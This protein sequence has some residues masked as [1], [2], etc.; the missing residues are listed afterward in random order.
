MKWKA[1]IISHTHWDRE[2]YLNSKY[3]NEWLVPFFD[4]LLAM[5]EKEEDYQFV[6][7]GQM[8]MIDDY[9]EE[10]AKA[11]KPV[12][13]FRNKIKKYVQE[14]R[15][16][17]GP[18]YLQPDWQL[19]S[20]ESLVRNMIVG[21]TKASEYGKC[22]N[23]GWLLDNFGQI[24]QTSQ[25][26]KE[27]E[28]KGLY[29]WRGVEMDPYNLQSEFIW[30][31]PDGTKLPS[32]YL[33]NSYRNVMR[34]A[35]YSDI[36]QA[37]IYA[38]VDKLKD[39]MTTK[40][41]LMM[42][43]YDQEM[44]PDDIQPYIKNG[45]LDSEDI[46]VV[47]SNP[48]SYLESVL[49]E[50]PDLVTLKG[51]LY[52]GRF[53][54]V[55]PGVMSTR[56][57]LKLQND[58]SQKA[59]EKYAEPLALIDYLHGGDYDA[60]TFEKAWELL[61]KNHPHDSICGVSIDDVHSD[62]EARSRDFH[63]LIDH[64][65]RKSMMNLAKRMDTSNLGELNYFAFN[66]S[67]YKRTEVVTIEGKDTI[68]ELPAFGYQLIDESV[69]VV[70]KIS[71]TD[72]IIDNGLI[73]V[74]INENGTFDIKDYETDAHY[75]QLGQLEDLGDAG[76]EYNYSYPDTDKSYYSTDVKSI[77]R[78]LSTS[79][80][81]VQVEV[82]YDIELPEKVVDDYTKRS[83]K[84]MKM[85]VRSVYTIEAN[86]KVVKVKTEILNTVRDHLVRVLFP[87]HIEADYAYAGS[88][89]DV[90]KRPIHIDDYD[91]S[92]IPE[93]VRKV[94]VGAREAKPN[95]IFFGR[96][97]VDIND[98][99]KGLAV[100][101]KGLPEYTVYEQDNTIALTLFRSVDWVAKDINTRIGDAGPEI[102]TPE[103][104]CLRQMTFEYA[105]YPHAHQYDEGLVLREAD[106]FNAP[107][108]NFVTDRHT[109]DLPC[110]KEFLSVEDDQNVIRVTSIKR[111]D[112]KKG[113]T[114][115]MYNGGLSQTTM[116]LN[117][118]YPIKSAK[119]VNFL[120][121]E[122]ELLDIVQNQVVL[123][124]GSKVIETIYIELEVSKT[125]LNQDVYADI[126]DVT[127]TTDFGDYASMPLVTEEDIQREE[128]RAKSWLPKIELPLYRRTALEAQLSTVLTKDRYH[129]SKVY[130]LGYELN[131]ARVKRRVH[132]YIQDIL[133]KK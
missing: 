50:N 24:S 61:L 31:S 103:A 13:I 63:F 64:Q 88:P 49:A 114:I 130:E 20:E 100:L 68:I 74:I 92:M 109:G 19:L 27:A 56:M 128:E 8:S 16:F 52:S 9:Y 58:T 48:E 123:N 17:V 81:K 51:A 115:R 113:I 73:Q 97:L 120:E 89:F 111:A 25:I 53:I 12:F 14:G 5:F 7:D 83:D 15:L 78:Y 59:I 77:I 11:G 34:L 106:R 133:N 37:R 117:C 93:N 127:A 94:I 132:D 80:A 129:E 10:L 98:G 99:Q 44:V 3:T 33:L 79:E 38:E 110:N 62:M 32:V 125:S 65:I 86:S 35:E 55:F 6:L 40:N 119:R 116:K 101:S 96:E 90:V 42:N 69:E 57:Y 30:E 91:E 60:T 28:I 107:V 87:T 2:W 36:M 1:Q 4:Q 70:N 71:R 122:K 21:N 124:V 126:Y 22:M 95:T 131:E 85:P 105:V 46:E 43:G 75:M 54:S 67:Y 102:Y 72:N 66:P 108:M 23:V 47:Q 121:N 29:A 118:C 76:D 39:F 82:R 84:L 104:Q 18:Y 41:I 26:H 45:G 112:K